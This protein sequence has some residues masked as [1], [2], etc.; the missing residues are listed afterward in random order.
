MFFLSNRNGSKYFTALRPTTLPYVDFDMLRYTTT[1]C[2]DILQCC[3]VL[4]C[5][6]IMLRCFLYWDVLP[7][8]IINLKCWIF[9]HFDMP[10]FGD[11]VWT[12]IFA[13]CHSTWIFISDLCQISWIEVRLIIYIRSWIELKLQDWRD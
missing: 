4:L 2:W 5:A 1:W 7:H 9:N 11:T 3:A 6:T 13:V 12:Y 10:Y 8:F